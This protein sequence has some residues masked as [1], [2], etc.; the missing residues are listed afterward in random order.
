MVCRRWPLSANH[1]NRAESRRASVSAFAWRDELPANWQFGDCE[2]PNRHI[3]VEFS[4]L[5]N[6]EKPAWLADPANADRYRRKRVNGHVAEPATMTEASR[7][8]RPKA[9]GLERV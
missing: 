1:S 4:N 2:F 9:E 8:D 7:N 6:G 5:P 3:L